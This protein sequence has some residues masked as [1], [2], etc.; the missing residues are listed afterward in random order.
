MNIQNI[1]EKKDWT[2]EQAKDWFQ[3]CSDIIV[4][5]K[6]EKTRDATI[7]VAEHCFKIIK[8]SKVK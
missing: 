2:V 3:T 6:S 8:N 7:I 1:I 4:N 5:T